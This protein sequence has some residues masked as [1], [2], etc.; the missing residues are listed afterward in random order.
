MHSLPVGVV[1]LG[2]SN[3]NSVHRMIERAGG[4]SI[5]VRE[6]ADLKRIGAVVLPGVG[7]FDAGMRA[8]KSASLTESL[9][10]FIVG[11]GKPTLGIC[12]GMHLL[13]RA[14]E[15]GTEKG[16]NIVN[17]DVRRFMFIDQQSYKVP[18]MG[19]NVVDPTRENSLIPFSGEE[20]RYYFVHSYKV[21]P[22][23]E[24]ISIGYADHGGKFCAAFQQENIFGVQ[25]HPE[26]S[27]RFGLGL[28]KRFIEL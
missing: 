16:L 28:I 17:A 3:Q 19:W 15:E 18:H 2:L 6:R 23:N 9:L 1:A 24:A 13:C 25:F 5:A 10:D 12:L 21:V 7:H 8:L 27:H 20:Q 4:R 14:S 11:S 26:K 22:D